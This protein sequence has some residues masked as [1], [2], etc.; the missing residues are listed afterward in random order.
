MKPKLADVLLPVR[1][2]R[3]APNKFIET[4]ERN[5]GNIERTRFIPPV[6]GS[7]G[8]GTFEVRYRTSVLRPVRG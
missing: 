3:L 2:E 8:F 5:K 1:V 6:I 4:I 7:R